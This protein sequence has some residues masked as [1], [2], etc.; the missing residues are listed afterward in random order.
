MCQVPWPAKTVADQSHLDIDPRLFHGTVSS[1]NRVCA[2]TSLQHNTIM[3]SGNIHQFK[4]Q[5]HH[6]TA[7]LLMAKGKGYAFID[8]NR[9]TMLN[10]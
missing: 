4:T 8:M 5:S 9:A 3:I 6:E 10:G 2:H 7:L 1:G